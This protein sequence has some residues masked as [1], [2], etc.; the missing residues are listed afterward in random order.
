MYL[1]FS[2]NEAGFISGERHDNQTVKAFSIGAPQSTA[3]QTP[4]KSPLL[5]IYN[6]ILWAATKCSAEISWHELVLDC[7]GRV[8]SPRNH[9]I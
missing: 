5:Q 1:E 6:K 2:D 7:S 9:F 8:G 3:P 4:K